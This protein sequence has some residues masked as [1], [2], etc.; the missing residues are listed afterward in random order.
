MNP[1]KPA[2]IA[3]RPAD[4]RANILMRGTAMVALLG[5]VAVGCGSGSLDPGEGEQLISSKLGPQI[6][7]TPGQ[8]KVACPDDVKIEN[9]AKFEC[10]MS[11][12]A[13]AKLRVSVTQ[14][15]DD[16]HISFKLVD[17]KLLNTD[18]A[19]TFVADKLAA[20]FRLDAADVEVSCPGGVPLENGREVEC[21]ATSPGQPPATVT[22]TQ[23]NGV[24]GVEITGFEAS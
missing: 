8:A 21:T 1:T 6:G 20:R 17:A 12:P 2:R 23:Y 18:N 24:G 15:N 11:T 14:T 9:D 13:G 22:L 5:F 19:E 10:T 4:F 3:C 16:G 7:L